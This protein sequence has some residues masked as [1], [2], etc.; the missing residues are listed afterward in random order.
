[1]DTKELDPVAQMRLMLAAP[2][3][4]AALKS[5]EE[6]ASSWHEMHIDNPTAE[7]DDL[8][9]CIPA[10]KAAIKEAEGND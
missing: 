6:A 10:A 3:L 4:L 8:C 2:K 7:C 9:T 1:M 5:F